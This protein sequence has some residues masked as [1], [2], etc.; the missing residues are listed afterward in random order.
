[1]SNGV[2]QCSSRSCVVEAEPPPAW[3]NWQSDVHALPGVRRLWRHRGTAERTA[4]LYNFVAIPT[5]RRCH[6]ELGKQRPMHRLSL[7][8]M[9]P[10]LVAGMACALG[11]GV[12]RS[13]D[14]FAACEAV[15]GRLCRAR[16][17]LP[18][19]GAPDPRTRPPVPGW[20]SSFV[21]PEFGVLVGAGSRFRDAGERPMTG[22]ARLGVRQAR[23]P[24]RWLGGGVRTGSSWGAGHAEPLL[25]P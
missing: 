20:D 9:K 7:E 6:A 21:Q 5:C 18:V 24:R 10:D 22:K 14:A 3:R 2:A 17:G 13:T 23:C 1:M 19:A 8:T 4:D 25:Q 15:G 11:C 16:C 12:G